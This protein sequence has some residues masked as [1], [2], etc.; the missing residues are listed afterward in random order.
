ML[1]KL[2]KGRRAA[3]SPA[4]AIPDGERVYA[5]GDVH[6]CAALLDR[7]LAKIAADDADRGP[8]RTTLIFLGDLVDR[9]PDSAGVIERLCRLAAERPDT[10]FLLGNHEEVFLESLR[11]EPKALRMFCRIGGRETILS[12][13]VDAADYDRMD[14]DELYDALTRR[15]PADHQAFLGGF[16]DLIVIGDYAFVHAGVRPDTDLAMQRGADL[17]WIRKP[18]LDHNG[19]LEKMI[20]HGHTIS[21]DLDVQSYRI[22]VDTGAY[23]TGKLTALGL[24]S[25]SRWTVQ[26]EANAE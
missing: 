25:T 6:G 18:F 17:R 2:L 3:A 16:E 11:G 4:A 5:I 22:G 21:Q 1:K 15:V 24:E 23:E 26:V 12:Y 19:T 9:G 20:V 8:A 10:R 7:L 14:Y 13:G